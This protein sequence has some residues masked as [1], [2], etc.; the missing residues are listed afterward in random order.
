MTDHHPFRILPWH[1][2]HPPHVLEQ[3]LHP[4]IAWHAG[5][6]KVD[7]EG[8]FQEWETL[9]ERGVIKDALNV[10]PERMRD[11]T[12]LVVVG[13]GSLHKEKEK[14]DRGEPN[15]Y[16]RRMMQLHAFKTIKRTIEEFTK[17]TVHQYA[18]EKD[19]NNVEL[20][21]LHRLDIVGYAHPAILDQVL[22]RKTSLYAPS[23]PF[24]TGHVPGGNPFDA[25]DQRPLST[26]GAP[27]LFV[28]HSPDMQ[29]YEEITP[30][31]EYVSRD[32]Y[33]GR[34]KVYARKH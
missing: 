7:F 3:F 24:N 34:M 9:R 26:Y 16:K 27:F 11:T 6:M 32:Q 8:W 14:R 13:L 12:V 1:A 25:A 18:F 29:I 21:F 20:A 10:R 19:F 23:V 17:L 4:L 28:D 33:F 30:S 5:Y 31:F 2:P 22:N 15:L